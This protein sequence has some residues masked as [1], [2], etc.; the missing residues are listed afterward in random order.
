M[1]R[2][3]SHRTQ[4]PAAEIL[5]AAIAAIVILYF[6]RAIFIPLALAIL[7]SFVLTPATLLLRRLWFGRVASILTT[8]FI[9][10]CLV[11][12]VGT[13][14]VRQ[15]TGLAENLPSYEN[16]LKEK[17]KG[18]QSAGGLSHILGRAGDTLRQLGNEIEGAQNKQGSP[19]GNAKAPIPVEI[20]QPEWQVLNQ[21]R[22]IIESVAEPLS[23]A[24]IVL[25]FLIFIML[26]REDLRDRIIRLVGARSVH[27]STAAMDEAGKRLSRYFLSQT[28][29][30][31]TFGVFIGLGLAF[32]GVPNAVL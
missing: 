29:V 9:A 8:I 18:L 4:L 5:V 11:V 12:A 19:S 30:N 25:V 17:I 14:V 23:T 7:L 3:A 1:D 28:L 27:K 22:S 2:S 6:G 15:V 21:Y 32:I 16:A 10:A 20:Q 26:Q 31:A 13:V 24:G